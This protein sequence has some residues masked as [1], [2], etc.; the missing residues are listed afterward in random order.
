MLFLP[1]FLI[2]ISLQSTARLLSVFYPVIWCSNRILSLYFYL[3]SVGLYFT[4][5]HSRF[6][7]LNLFD[8]IALTIS[9]PP[10]IYT[11]LRFF[12]D[13]P[14][15]IQLISMKVYLYLQKLTLFEYMDIGTIISLSWY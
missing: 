11:T 14:V 4:I 3:S 1:Y 12:K 8:F 2:P 10:S 6:F 7:H 5:V 9:S 15:Y 13:L